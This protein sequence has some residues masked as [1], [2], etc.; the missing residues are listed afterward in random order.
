M[1]KSCKMKKENLKREEF[2][3]IPAKK[4]N[5]IVFSMAYI[6]LRKWRRLASPV[7]AAENLKSRRGRKNG[8]LRGRVSSGVRRGCGERIDQSVR[9]AGVIPSL[10]K[11]A[12]APRSRRPGAR[13]HVVAS[14]SVTL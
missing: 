8:Q 13:S 5:I 10:L 3:R 1:V 11:M 9:L 14:S 2:I 12:T 7:W 6:L 4:A